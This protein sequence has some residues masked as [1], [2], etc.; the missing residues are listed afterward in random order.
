MTVA[1]P[2][3][4][5]PLTDPVGF[6]LVV[7][8]AVWFIVGFPRTVLDSESRPPDDDFFVHG[9]ETLR[10]S[11]GWFG[12]AFCR[13]GVDLRRVGVRGTVGSEEGRGSV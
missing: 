10:I 2:V 7:F 11:L 1:L 5:N 9:F 8:G 13:F 3:L 12:L 4:K 6:A